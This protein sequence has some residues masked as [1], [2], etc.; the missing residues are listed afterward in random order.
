MLVLE[1]GTAREQSERKDSEPI[2]ASCVG[3]IVQGCADGTGGGHKVHYRL[4]R[5]CSRG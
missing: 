3:Y 5:V 4:L 2:G 1:W